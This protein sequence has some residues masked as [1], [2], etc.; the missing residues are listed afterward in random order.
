MVS[1][2]SRAQYQPV[3][4][5]WTT[6]PASGYSADGGETWTPFGGDKSQISTLYGHTRLLA[7]TTRSGGAASAR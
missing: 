4:T 2:D 6:P 7:S 3:D 5:S 1:S